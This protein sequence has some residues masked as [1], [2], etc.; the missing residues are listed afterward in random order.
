MQTTPKYWLPMHIRIAPD[1][2]GAVLLDLQR[3][4]YFGIGSKETQAIARVALNLPYQPRALPPQ[5]M[6]ESLAIAARLTSAGLLT[7][8]EPSSPQLGMGQIDLDGALSS[9]GHEIEVP[10]VLHPGH[11][12]QFFRAC[13]WAKL[14]L[15]HRSL[16]WIAQSITRRKQAAGAAFQLEDGAALVG[17]FRRLRPLA[18]TAQDRCLFHALA[19]VRFLS[20][21]QVFPSWVIG[22]RLRPW[23]A[24][25][26]VQHHTLLLDASPEEVCEYAPILVI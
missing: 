23:A 6:E 24:H 2:N 3:N 14:S 8:A 10:H 11:V 1:A 22:V 25:S 4:R 26:W 9:V 19:L 20:Y 16:Y 5:S 15:R 7:A 18:F 13:A 17:I 12:L 21:Y